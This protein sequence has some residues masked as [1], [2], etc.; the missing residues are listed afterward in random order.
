MRNSTLGI[1]VASRRGFEVGFG[2]T[3]RGFEVGFTAGTG[4]TEGSAARGF[5][6]G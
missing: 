5:E 3:V 6:V 4:R 1:D 2:M